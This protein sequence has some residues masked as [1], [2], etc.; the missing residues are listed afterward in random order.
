MVSDKLAIEQLK[1]LGPQ[2]GDQPYQRHFRSIGFTRKH[3]FPKKGSAE[4][5]T[6]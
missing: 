4:R 1:T 5:E 2:S 3:A 6:V